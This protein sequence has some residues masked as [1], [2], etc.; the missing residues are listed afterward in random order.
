M[1]Q[2]HLSQSAGI[3][4]RLVGRVFERFRGRVVLLRGMVLKTFDF[5]SAGVF[6]GPCE[7]DGD[8]GRSHFSIC[9][10]F[11]SGMPR[12]PGKKGRNGSMTSKINALYGF[13]FSL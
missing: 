1:G 6:G 8:G 7:S 11:S 5:S 2:T 13:C 12:V 9:S 4:N 3:L 10:L